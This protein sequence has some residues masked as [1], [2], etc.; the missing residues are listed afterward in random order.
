ML[1]ELMMRCWG[2]FKSVKWNKN[3]YSELFIWHKRAEE[4]EAAAK[5]FTSTLR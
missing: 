5:A 2:E 4:K 1:S 3:V